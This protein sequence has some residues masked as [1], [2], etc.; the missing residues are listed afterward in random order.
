MQFLKG[1]KIH[2]GGGGAE[3]NSNCTAND[4]M[5]NFLKLFGPLAKQPEII[6]QI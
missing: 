4:M 6:T 1:F 2:G 3:V 5:E